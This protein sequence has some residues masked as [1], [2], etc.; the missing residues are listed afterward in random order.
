MTTSAWNMLAGPLRIAKL[1]NPRK[2]GRVDRR[3]SLR[4]IIYRHR[5]PPGV[6]PFVG[7]RN[8]RVGREGG[9]WVEGCS[10][11]RV[12]VFRPSA[13]GCT[14]RPPPSVAP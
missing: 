5:F 12:S 8:A 14:S 13:L 2:E 10:G 4:K 11:W 1:P 9:R 7:G 6:H 3:T